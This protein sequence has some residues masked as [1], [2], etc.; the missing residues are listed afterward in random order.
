MTAPI[1]Y[2]VSGLRGRIADRALFDLPTLRIGPG[3][4]WV[5]GDEG[6]GK[7]TLLRLLAGDQPKQ[8]DRA[9]LCG[10]DLHADA[11]GYQQ[12]VA[13]FEPEHGAN[14]RT[15]ASTVLADIAKQFL[16][17]NADT[18][19][20]LAYALGLE[21]H[22]EKPLYMLSTGSRRKLWIVAALASGAPLTLLD[23]PFAALDGASIRVLRE[24][25]QEVAEHPGRAFVVADYT[26]P[27]GVAVRDTVLLSG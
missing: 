1:I 16:N 18:A 6:C 20:E 2:Q 14:D 27:E 22:I 10:K 8:V 11:K 12:H 21:S 5:L 19:S 24:V 4:T 15:P 25:L 7:T 13:W 3:V 23:M 26:V 9:T 17:W